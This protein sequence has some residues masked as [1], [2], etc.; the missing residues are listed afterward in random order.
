MHKAVC[1]P[2]KPQYCDGFACLASFRLDLDDPTPATG[3]T[4][5]RQTLHPFKIPE[6]ANIPRPI[7]CCQSSFVSEQREHDG[8]WVL[9]RLGWVD[10]CFLDDIQARNAL[11]EACKVGSR[12]AAVSGQ[13]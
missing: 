11:V 1:S 9:V 10:A 5:Q 7:H 6:A 3:H 13:S 12:S 8:I 4:R 2:Q